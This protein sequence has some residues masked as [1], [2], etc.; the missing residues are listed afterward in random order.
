MSVTVGAAVLALMLLDLGQLFR[1]AC[2]CV[3]RAVGGSAT[4]QRVAGRVV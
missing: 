1:A 3:K 2:R 4:E